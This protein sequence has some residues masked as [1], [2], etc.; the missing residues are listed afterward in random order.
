M[1]NSWLEEAY[2][3]ATISKGLTGKNPSVGCVIVNSNNIVGLGYTSKGGRPHAEENA[4]RMA[5]NRAK[6]A[7]LY[8]SLEP[9]HI[10]GNKNSCTNQ[11]I[12]SGISKVVIGMLDPNKKT[13]KR[14]LEELK[15]KGI[16]VEIASLNFENFLFYLSHY[17]YSVKKRSL[18]TLKLATSSDNKI[19]YSDGTSKWIT[20]KLA[21]QHVHQIRSLNDAVLVGANTAKKDNPTLNSRIKGFRSINAR[22]ILDTNLS[23]NKKSKLFSTS[24]K[25]PLIVFS[26]EKDIHKRKEREQKGISLFRVNKDN[27]KLLNLEE[28]TKKIYEIGFQKILIEGGAKVASSFLNHNIIDI[29]YIYKSSNFIGSK[30]LDAMGEIKL[31]KNFFLYD[32]KKLDDNRIEIWLNKKIIH[33]FRKVKCSQELLQI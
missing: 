30:G 23:L 8:V 22:I 29:I 6:G 24:N 25:L 20:S 26:N 31:N 27:N 11:I 1:R 13:F 28:I 3:Q 15:K 32:E 7:T 16:D 19:T 5:G 21:R 18:F 4:I 17:L 9:C 33:L 12:K 10:L 14:G 2:Y